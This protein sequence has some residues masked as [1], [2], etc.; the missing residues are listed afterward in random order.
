MRNFS[1]QLYL[2]EIFFWIYIKIINKYYLRFLFFF[3]LK[4]KHVLYVSWIFHNVWSRCIFLLFLLLKKIIWS[5]NEWSLY[6]FNTILCKSP[7]IY[8]MYSI[9]TIQF[10]M[11]DSSYTSIFYCLTSYCN[12]YRFLS[13]IH[14]SLF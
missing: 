9:L 2:S 6:L 14:F 5:M 1:G 7:I 8:N 3:S 10:M 12:N 11:I 13:I 4:Q